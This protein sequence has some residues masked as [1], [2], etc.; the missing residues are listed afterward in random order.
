MQSS[1]TLSSNTHSR[2]NTMTEL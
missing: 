1:L 2:E